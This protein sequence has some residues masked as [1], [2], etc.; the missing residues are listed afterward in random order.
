MPEDDLVGLVFDRESGSG[1]VTDDPDHPNRILL[2]SFIRIAD[3][4][5]DTSLQ[6]SHS[7]H[8]VYDREIR[9]IVEKTIDRDIPPQGI[10]CRSSI[11]VRTDDL[12]SFRLDL[13]KF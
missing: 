13:F 11:T 5:N 7:A 3:R 1:S 9:N 12:P 4:S 10:L 6:V 8:I 2:K